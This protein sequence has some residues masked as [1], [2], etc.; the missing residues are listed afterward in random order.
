VPREDDVDVLH[1]PRRAQRL[2]V[3]LQR[4]RT[5]GRHA[6]VGCGLRVQRARDQRVGRDVLDEVVGPE[7][8]AT[9]LVVEDRVRRR[10]AGAMQHAQGAVAQAQLGAVGERPRHRRR[11][12]P[13]AVALRHRQQR[14]VH[15][16]RDPVL[17]HDALGERVV[18]VHALLPVLHARGQQVQRG[19]LGA[20]AAREDRHEAEVVDVLMGY[21]DQ[22]EVLH[23]V[24]ARRE[25]ALELVER[26]AGVRAAVDQRERLVLDEVG[27]DA[28]DDERRRQR[29][30]VDAGL[31][32]ALQRRLRFAHR[33]RGPAAWTRA[34]VMSG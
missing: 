29:Q 12:T 32:C 20:R 17:G 6:I 19:D 18:G 34:T 15:V 13:R 11:A 24:A 4:V 7:H 1:R 25:R 16:L 5:V 21:D 3:D 28:A 9:L 31:G 27:V 26:R 23:A 8:D 22:P 10:V 2:H 33:E 14:V 30:A